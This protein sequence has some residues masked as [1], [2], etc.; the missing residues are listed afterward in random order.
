MLV[1][2]ELSR[3]GELQVMDELGARIDRDDVIED[4]ELR[5]GQSGGDG[6]LEGGDVEDLIGSFE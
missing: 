1:L 5:V 4:K 2:S 3:V 6:G